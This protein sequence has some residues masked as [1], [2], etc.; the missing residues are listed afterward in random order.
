MP[1]LNDYNQF[2]GRHWET[3][4]VSNFFAYRGLQNPYTGEPFSESFFLG[5]SGGAVMGY[6]FFAYKGYDPMARILTRNT[7]DPLDTLLSRLGVVQNIQRT[8]KPDKAEANLVETLRDGVPAIAWADAYSLPYNAFSED[9]GMWL[10][11]PILVYGY[12]KSQDTVWIADRARVPLTTTT[13]ELVAARGR[14]K[15][16]K[17]QL[18]TLDPPLEEKI[19][20]AVQAGIWDCI[21]LY[22]EKPPKGSKNNFGLNALRWWADLLVKPKARQ[23]WE[24]VF[25]PGQKF[26]AGLTSAFHDINI[27]GKE[28]HAERDVYADFLDEAS[29]ILDNPALKDAA[30][31][32]R[33]STAAWDRLSQAL[34]PDEVPLFQETRQLMLRR[35]QRFLVEGNA[36]LDEIHA[37]DQRL[38]EI[39]AQITPDHPLKPSEVVDMRQNIRDHVMA[40]HDHEQT[41]V[42]ALQEAMA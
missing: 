26:Y 37:I 25:P 7:F 8:A 24:R 38:A 15:K 22:T 36:A 14:V 42:T 4:T 32:F 2:A 31:V 5:V 10:M 11:F 27:F 30:E 29:L 39:K 13:A 35:H 1:V 6:F 21:K 9:E 3:G 41:A 20:A 17:F 18:L 16:D 23:S 33:N 28:G 12:D 19:P 40:V 34:L